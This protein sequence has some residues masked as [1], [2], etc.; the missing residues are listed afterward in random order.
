MIE[1]LRLADEDAGSVPFLDGERTPAGLIRLACAL[2]ATAASLAEIRDLLTWFGV[3]RSRPAIHNWCHSFAEYHK[4]AFTAEP[5]RIAVDEKQVQLAEEQ[6]MWLYVAIDVDSKVVLHARLSAH[7][8]RDPAETFLRELKEKHCAE[9]A[10][11]L[12]DGMGYLTA[13][14]RVDLSGHLDYSDRNIVE[15][16]F[17]TYTM[18]IGRFHETWN[19]SQPSAERWLTAYSYYY[20]SP[21]ESPS[22]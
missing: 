4:Q 13:L 12:V 6:K 20:N 14:A 2:H 18:R 10:E 22:A 17:Q 11:F 19:G 5:D 7:R 9:D 8:G 16:L 21:P 1:E 15:K 3:S